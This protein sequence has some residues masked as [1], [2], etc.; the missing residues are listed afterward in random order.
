MFLPTAKQ[1]VRT[2][3]AATLLIRCGLPSP[4]AWLALGIGIGLAL[5]IGL[6]LE[7][8]LELGLGLGPGLGLGIVLGLGLGLGLGLLFW[9]HNAEA[10]S[11]Q[12]I[13]DADAIKPRMTLSDLQMVTRGEVANEL[14]AA[15]MRSGVL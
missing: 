9:E 12:F 4:W 15:V 8:G 2:Q 3:A 6:G 7:L 10:V 11:M 1:N 14:V 5:G 13:C